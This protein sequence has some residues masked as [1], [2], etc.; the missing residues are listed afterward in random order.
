MPEEGGEEEVSME[1]VYIMSTL[2]I[3]GLGIII[4]DKVWR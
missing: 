3:L 4:V 2:I 1:H